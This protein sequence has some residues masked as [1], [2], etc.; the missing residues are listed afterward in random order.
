MATRPRPLPAAGPYLSPDEVTFDTEVFLLTKAR[1]KALAQPPA[2]VTPPPPPA[3][4]PP[5]HDSPQEDVA[6]SVVT[7][8]V[9]GDVPPETWNKLGIKLIPKLK[10]GK[11]LTL[12][13]DA[14]VA[15]DGLQAEALRRELRQVF[16]DLGLSDRFHVE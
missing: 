3:V 1:A 16:A 13:L 14:S 7:I 6:A 15:T 9:T 12:Q 2:I 5:P 11:T 8:R 10:S 4:H